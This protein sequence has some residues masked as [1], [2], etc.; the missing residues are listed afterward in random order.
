M[1][2]QTIVVVALLMWPA[3]AASQTSR[4]EMQATPALP[5]IGLPLSQ[6]GLPLRPIGLPLPPMG[7]PAQVE[8]PRLP[9]SRPD[10]GHNSPSRHPRFHAPAILYLVSP[11]PWSGPWLQ[12]TTTPG[13]AV[14]AN[15][16]PPP[17][18]VI[19]R[20][21]LDIQ[22]VTDLQVFVDG[23]FVGS[24]QDVG[25]ALELEPGTRRIEIRAPG[26]ELVVFDARIVAERT[27]TYRATLTAIRAPEKAT[28]APPAASAEPRQTF[29]FIPGCYLGNIPPQQVR[30][31]VDCD[32]SRLITHTP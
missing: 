21:E 14:P 5:P 19:G 13:V 22:P 12:A 25:M 3:I 28:V 1:K 8:Q 29:Y 26:Y 2:R 24:G 31:P 11:Y 7:L 18:A 17:V 23:A 27:I 6:I 4:S 16:Q 30:L 9:T 15:Q 32:L 20:L 10:R